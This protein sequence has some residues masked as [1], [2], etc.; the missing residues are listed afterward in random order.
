MPSPLNIHPPLITMGV[1][2]AWLAVPDSRLPAAHSVI[3]MT[4]RYVSNRWKRI[5]TRMDE[6]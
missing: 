2:C 3:G 6:T 4:S 5:A 1:D